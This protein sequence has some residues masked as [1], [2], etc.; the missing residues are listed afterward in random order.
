MEEF[1]LNRAWG[2]RG[3]PTVLLLNN[4]QLYQIAN[5]YATFEQMKNQVLSMLNLRVENN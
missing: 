2:V 3:Y 4:D 5:G 1:N